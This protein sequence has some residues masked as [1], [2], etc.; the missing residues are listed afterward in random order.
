MRLIHK[1]PGTY[2]HEVKKLLQR[3]K[4]KS[5]GD[6]QKYLA[7]DTEEGEMCVLCLHKSISIHCIHMRFKDFSLRKNSVAGNVLCFQKLLFDSLH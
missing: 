6:M 5:S 2:F 3:K 7:A 1:N 4:E